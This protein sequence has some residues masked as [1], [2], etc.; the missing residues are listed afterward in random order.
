MKIQKWDEINGTGSSRERMEAFLNAEMDTYA[1]LQLRFSGETSSERFESLER[2]HQQGK[3]P[4]IDHYEV[5]YTAPLLPYKDLGTMLEQIYEKFNRDYPL[6]FQG[7]SLSVSDVVALRQN[8]TVTCHYVDRIGFQELPGFLEPENYLKNAE[9]ALEDDYGM[10]DGIINNGK[11]DR[12]KEGEE[13]R[14][15]VL[16]QLKETARETEP[17]KPIRKTEERSRQ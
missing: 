11:A 4:Q 16:R 14:P 7:H 3:E 15:S 6:D 1:I 12:V 13:K 8:R 2:L 9:M 5:V 10:I 17:V